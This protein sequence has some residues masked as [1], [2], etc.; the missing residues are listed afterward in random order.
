[1]GP[2]MVRQALTHPGT[3][4]VL[5][6]AVRSTRIC[7]VSAKKFDIFQ[8]KMLRATRK[9]PHVLP[10]ISMKIINQKKSDFFV[11]SLH[12][13]EMSVRGNVVAIRL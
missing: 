6:G 4:Q 8:Q 9:R 12:D 11:H 2:D 7:Q 3:S 10:L 13:H 5:S 1:M